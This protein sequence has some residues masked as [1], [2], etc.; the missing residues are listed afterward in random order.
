[1]ADPGGG[2][3]CYLPFDD[4]FLQKLTKLNSTELITLFNHG[5]SFT[6]IYMIYAIILERVF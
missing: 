6:N 3:L 2:G 1:M 5:K 4:F